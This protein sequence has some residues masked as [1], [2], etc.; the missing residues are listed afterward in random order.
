MEDQ[1]GGLNKI[2]DVLNSFGQKRGL[3]KESKDITITFLW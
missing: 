1:K 3:Q 2:E